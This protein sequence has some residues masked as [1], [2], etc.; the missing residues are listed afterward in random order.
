MPPFGRRHQ[1][2]SSRICGLRVAPCV[3]TIY[4]LPRSVN[5]AIAY[6]EAQGGVHLADRFEAE[7]RL[8]LAAIKAGPTHFPSYNKDPIFRRARLENFPYV[9]VFREKPG[10][11]RVTVIRH[12]RRHP[13]Y[14]MKRK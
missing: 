12:D 8:G 3:A 5:E 13:L 10:V 1:S 2:P 7:L 6:Y 11:V 4:A 9:I 14:G